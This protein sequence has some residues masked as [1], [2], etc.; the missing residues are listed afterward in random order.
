VKRGENLTILFDQSN[1]ELALDLMKEI[2]RFKAIPQLCKL[3]F[4]KK[5]DSFP[6]CIISTL[7]GLSE[8]D[9][10]IVLSSTNMI[11][12]LHVHKVISPFSRLKSILS[13]SLYIPPFPIES[14]IRIMSIN[15]AE[16]E[17]YQDN[18]IK[19]LGGVERIKLLT[20]AGTDV[21]FQVRKFGGEN[22]YK[23]VFPSE[24]ALLHLGEIWTSI[25]EDTMDG[26][27]VYDTSLFMGKIHSKLIIQVSKGNIIKETIV[28][29]SDSVINEF[30]K[31]LKKADEN[32]RKPAEL[33]IGLNSNAQISGCIME[34]ESVRGTCH[35]DLGDNTAFGGL[36][37]SNFHGGGV[38]S[39]PTLVAN[40]RPIIVEGAFLGKRNFNS[41][42]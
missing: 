24:H 1:E 29:K 38:M 2:K 33:G 5:M 16:Y 27:L 42:R 23:A 6:K 8:E 15:L 7:E 19:A 17:N 20:K 25:V 11:R 31:A 14:L 3:P 12:N 22:V 18:L 13:R 4:G 40:G 26:M 35:I 9:G 28:G 21:S 30:L 37:K 32:A 36:N 34:D 10:L 41:F 39:Y